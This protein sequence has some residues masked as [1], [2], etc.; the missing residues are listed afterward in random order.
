VLLCGDPLKI[1]NWR[2]EQA[3]N[4]TKQKRPDLLK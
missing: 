2:M 4:L 3:E 1:E